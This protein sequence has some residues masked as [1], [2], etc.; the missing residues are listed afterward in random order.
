MSFGY[1]SITCAHTVDSAARGR[2]NGLMFELKDLRQLIT[3]AGCGTISR[4]AEQM[5]ISQPALS[6]AMQKL[7]EDVGV[8]LFD[9]ARNRVEL[10]ENGKFFVKIAQGIVSSCDEG[11]E[12][13]RAFDRERRTFAVGSCAPAPLWRLAD[14]L[15]AGLAEG[16][17]STRLC[18]GEE[19]VSGLKSGA[20]RLI[21]LNYP[22]DEEGIICRKYCTERLFLCLP[23]EHR[24]ASRASVSFAD[25][26]GITML[27]YDGIGVWRDVYGRLPHTRFIVQSG[28]DDFTDL[29][30]QSS[31]PSFATDLSVGSAVL[32]QGRVTIPVEDE[33]AVQT[34]YVLA[35][36]S[37]KR[38]LPR[39]ADK[40]DE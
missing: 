10:N 11:I 40:E 34:F 28:Y 17:L 7:E 9:R 2:Y 3:V 30:R 4:A 24:L 38:Y 18:G 12:R 15:S 36:E 33:G 31:L 13:V 23:A 16:R 19:L 20:F 37:D 1:C 26:D 29:V 14:H 25:I 32:P 5:Y 35:R 39:T 22:V 27:L 6:R 8:Q 21:I